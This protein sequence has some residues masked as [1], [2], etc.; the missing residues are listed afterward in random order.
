MTNQIKDMKI[1]NFSW[2][3]NFFEQ[4]RDIDV[5]LSLQASYDDLKTLDSASSSL[6]KQSGTFSEL[7]LSMGYKR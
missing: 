3:R 6:K 4:Y 1:L 5:L 7:A 2:S